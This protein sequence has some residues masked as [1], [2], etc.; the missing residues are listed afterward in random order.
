MFKEL[1]PNIRTR[2]YL[3]FLSK[4][5]SSMIFPFMAIYFTEKINAETAS[6]LLIINIAV[7]FLANY[8]AV[9]LLI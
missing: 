4:V 8:T 7:Q 3:S 9:I 2:I 1:H 6:I 5:V